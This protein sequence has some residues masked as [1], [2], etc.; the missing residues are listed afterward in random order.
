MSQLLRTRSGGPYPST[1]AG[2]GGLPSIIPDIPICA[3]LMVLYLCSAG[4]NITIFRRNNGRNHKFILSGLL[5]GFS[6]ARVATLVL[7]ITWTT[8]Q[9][10]IRLAIAAQIFV[11]AGVLIAYI[12]NLILAQRILRAKQPHI[13]WH[14]VLRI[15]YKF[16]YVGIGIALAMVISS[17]VV[18]LYTLDLHTRSVC[19]DIQLAALTYL[20][21]FTCLP[22]IHVAVALLL[23]RSRDEENFGKG[24]MR[25]KLVIVTL[26]ACLCM[27]IAGFKAGA[28]WSPARPVSNP[29]WYQSKACFYVFN[30]AFEIAILILLTLSRIDR[31]FHIPNGSD[32][33][34]HYTQAEKHIATES[35]SSP[36][37][38]D[39]VDGKDAV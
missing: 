9:K 7:R 39:S 38:A 24:S 13:G 27:T 25:V 21:V 37:E 5:T 28:T 31:R 17:V 2:L 6:M 10:N 19:R 1:T 22:I 16:L 20:L 29:A 26:S 12:I 36:G 3:V 33:P 18:S 34:G 32:G 30:F 15:A 11:N 35:E 14:P 8:R 23:P 4:T